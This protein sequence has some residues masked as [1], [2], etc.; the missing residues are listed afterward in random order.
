MYQNTLR[1]SCISNNLRSSAS[2]RMKTLLVGLTCCFSAANTFAQ[3]EPSVGQELTFPQKVT[4]AGVDTYQFSAYYYNGKKAYNLR[5]LALCTTSGE[6]LSLKVNPS[7]TS[8][9]TLNKKGDKAQVIIYDLWKANK[10]LHEFKKL[11][12]PSAICYSPDAQNIL[13]ATADTLRFFD[14]RKYNQTDRMAMPFVATAMTISPN[15]YYLA[16]SNGKNLV[17]WNLEDK[18]IRK[19]FELETAVNDFLFSANSEAFAV[20]TADGLLSLYGTSNFFIQQS[21]EAMGDAK[22][23]S[24]H[25]EGKYISVVTGDNR[26][27]VLNLMDNQDRSYIE[28]A[29][30]GI[31]VARFVRDGKR[32]V[33]LTYNTKESLVYKLMDT[34]APN[35][36]QLLSDELT[37]RMDE[38]MKMMPGETLEEY[39]L[40]VNDENLALQMRVFEQ[41]ISTR[42]ANDMVQMSEVTFGNYNTASQQLAVNFDNMPAIYLDVP[43][44]EVN[45]FMNPENLDFRNVKYGLTENDK[46]E[47]IYAD[48]YN[49]ATGKTYVFDNL[50]RQSLDF[51]KSDENFVPLDLVQQ[52][53]MEEMK[54]Q[55]LTENV[56]E[57]AKKSNTIS[58]HTNISVSSRIETSQDANGNKIMNYNVKFS[59]EVENGF[60]AQEDFAP[61]KY[62]IDDSGAAKSMLTIIKTALETEFAQYVKEGKKVQIKI[63][64]MADALPINGKIAYDGS[65]GDFVNE[66]VYKNDEL[67]NI[68][69]TKTDGITQNEQLA[70]L[71]AIGVKKNITGNI[72]SLEGMIA[73]YRHDIEVASEKGG[74]FRRATVEFTFIDAFILQ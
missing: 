42:M 37:N 66:P 30:G 12:Q 74:E 36:T 28:N 67:S 68:T 41:E 16:A 32:Q 70:F 23:C 17:V 14:A 38:W 33:F 72:P 25:P 62:K 22:A 27:A 39:K 65:Y 1:L 26:I 3:S 40:R 45:D 54:L 19:E 69:V 6:V 5:N 34:L 52:S 20:L 9:A 57:D 24:F 61:G 59:Y 7:G 56:V 51:L 58:D 55:E 35:Y 11:N 2:L 8:F 47:I 50:D 15:G 63:T 71:R 53:N 44:G 64:G 46:F 73:D 29:L 18:T 10:K 60:S 4:P 13:I 49:K 43:T 48:V 31:K 21:F